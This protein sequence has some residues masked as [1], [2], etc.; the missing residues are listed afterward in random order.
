M[1]E[2]MAGEAPD[3]SGNAGREDAECVYLGEGI[4]CCFLDMLDLHRD[5]LM[6]QRLTATATACFRCCM[7]EEYEFGV[8]V[9]SVCFGEEGIRHAYQQA[10]EMIKIN[11]YEEAGILYYGDSPEIG[12]VLPREAQELSDRAAEFVKCRQYEAMEDGFRKVLHICR[13]RHTDPRLILHWLKA[14]DERLGIGRGQ[15]EY[16]GIIGAGQLMEI[17]EDYRQRLFTRQPREIPEH[18]GTSVRR[19][20]DYL[21]A[22]YKEQ[23]GLSEAAELNPAY[24]SFLFKQEMGGGSLHI[25]WSFGWSMRRRCLAIQMIRSRPWQ[26]G[27]ASTIITIFPRHSRR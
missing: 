8:G 9:S 5:S 13:M 24:L 22:H 2:R 6:K 25:C 20:V 1:P 27:R 23:I 16:A 18:A 14:M 4:F 11:F 26:A 3:S 21:Q 19:V 10:R 15:E 17:C 12:K 7:E